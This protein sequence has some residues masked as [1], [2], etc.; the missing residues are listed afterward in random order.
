MQMNK[1]VVIDSRID[2]ESEE[3]LYK[4]GIKTIK[5]PQ[6]NLFDKPISAHPDMFCV[7]I[8]EK[9]FVDKR[10]AHL[11][12]FWD[13]EIISREVQNGQAY[14]YPYDVGFNCAV[15]GNHIICNKQ[16]T[17]SEILQYSNEQN[18]NIINVKQGY[19]K[20]STCIVD[21]NSII[22]EDESIAKAARNFGINVLMI[23][24]GFVKLDRYDYGFIGGASGLINNRLLFNGDI[25]MH[26]NYNEIKRFCT[27]RNVE[28]I[29]LNSKQLY[30]IGSILEF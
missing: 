4:M 24:K 17:A 8:K 22:T 16:Y 28:I 25:K 14:K 7:K 19:A 18:M 29:S 5:I 23:N 12:D 10:I 1:T 13:V 6:N 21:D 2:I 27:S 26:P 15:M 20:C 9:R 3:M 30:D 11:F